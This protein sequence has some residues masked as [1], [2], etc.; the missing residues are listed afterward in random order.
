VNHDIAFSQMC[1]E[2]GY[3]DFGGDVE[4]SQNNFCGLGTTG[5]GVKGASFPDART[6]VKAHI[7]HLKAYASK[8]PVVPPIVDPRFDLV[9]RGIASL[10]SDLSGLWATDPNYGNKI[11]A[12]QRR[13]LDIV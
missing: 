3:L 1:L 11:L 7:Q 4:P 6:G 9:A 5:G 2:T 8:D 12:V 13:L 10:V